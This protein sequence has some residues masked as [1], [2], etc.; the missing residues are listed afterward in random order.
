MG[1][2]REE[3]SDEVIQTLEERLDCFASLAM[4]ESPNPVASLMG[5][6]VLQVLRKQRLEFFLEVFLEPIK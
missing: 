4:T 6:I 1:R 3:R 2:H 5:R